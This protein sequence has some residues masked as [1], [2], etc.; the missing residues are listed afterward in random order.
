MTQG[1]RRE[2]W[3]CNQKELEAGLSGV[4]YSVSVHPNGQAVVL[5]CFVLYMG[6]ISS[7]Y[8]L[9]ML[10][11]LLNVLY[12]T[13]ELEHLVEG[14]KVHEEPLTWHLT[15]NMVTLSYNVYSSCT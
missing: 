12:N 3:E 11:Q 2:A 14:E 4:R 15:F 5:S 9:F 1:V 8:S 13:P 10:H 7:D 6:R